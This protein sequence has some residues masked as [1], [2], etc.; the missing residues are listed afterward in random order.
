MSEAINKLHGQASNT[1][2]TA[3]NRPADTDTQEMVKKLELEC[4]EHG[5]ELAAFI[6]VKKAGDQPVA[7]SIGH[8]YNVALLTANLAKAMKNNLIDSIKI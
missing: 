4:I 6:A 3:P 1:E 8:Q 2:N 7:F 5:F